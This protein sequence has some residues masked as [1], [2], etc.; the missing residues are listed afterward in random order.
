MRKGNPLLNQLAGIDRFLAPIGLA[1]TFADWT[2]V[3]R[4]DNLLII[5][6]R[7]QLTDPEPV[8]RA[9][10][11]DETFYQLMWSDQQNYV[12]GIEGDC[13]KQHRLVVYATQPLMPTWLWQLLLTVGV[14]GTFVSL[15]LLLS[16]VRKP[17]SRQPPG[18]H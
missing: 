8:A 9:R 17:W 5:E 15:R 14:F 6:R 18:S 2:Q 7:R 11:T 10:F 13:F 4:A 1:E 3:L 16:L 12:G